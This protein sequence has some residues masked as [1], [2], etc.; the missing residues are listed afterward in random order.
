MEIRTLQ[1][2]HEVL[3]Y[4]ALVGETRSMADARKRRAEIER[5]KNERPVVAGPSS[6]RTVVRLF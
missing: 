3:E 4:M 6:L 5:Q 2:W 1:Q